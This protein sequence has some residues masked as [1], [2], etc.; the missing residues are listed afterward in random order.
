[1]RIKHTPTANPHLVDSTSRVSQLYTA[2]LRGDETRTLS[3]RPARFVPLHHGQ[4]VVSG[5]DVGFVVSN[6]YG[7]KVG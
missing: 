2:A 6:R 3:P 7:S 4:S 1:M 5:R